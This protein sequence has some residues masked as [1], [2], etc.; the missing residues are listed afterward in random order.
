MADTQLKQPYLLT[1]GYLESASP[2]ALSQPFHVTAQ[3][4]LNA[5]WASKVNANICVGFS[6]KISA[7][8]TPEL[9]IVGTIFTKVKT[10]FNFKAYDADYFKKYNVVLNFDEPI[11]GSTTLNFDAGKI[12]YIASS[13]ESHFY[14]NIVANFNES[15]H[16]L[17]KL[18][19]SIKTEFFTKIQ[20]E[21]I[22]NLCTIEAYVNLGALSKA[23]AKFDLNFIKGVCF[24]IDARYEK[25]VYAILSQSMRCGT[26]IPT[27]HLFDFKQ[28]QG[29]IISNFANTR[30][31]NTKPIIRAIKT[32]FERST[33]LQQDCYV[34]WQENERA[35]I[36]KNIVFDE[37]K[38]LSHIRSTLWQEMI[39]KRKQITYSYE[40]AHVFEKSF[41]FDWDKGL[42]LRLK[43]DLKW[44]EARAIYYQKHDVEPWT[45][46]PEPQY[47]GS[48][49]LNFICLCHDV[50]SH[51]V[52]LNFG[53]SDCLP[54]IANQ[55]WWYIVNEIQVTRLDN[56]EII[57]VLNGNYRTDRQSW[58]WSYSLTIPASELSKLDPVDARPVI[59]KIMVNGFEHLMLL[60]NRTR[61]RQ[62]AQ[63]TY[64]LSGR[65]VSA[66]LDAPSSPPRAFLQENER[67]SVQ[68]VQ[69]EIDRS[70]YPDLD[71]NWQLI[72][73]LGWIV[74]NESFSYSNL[75]PIKAI[76]EIASAGGG[77]VYS[78]ADS[79]TISIK[80][81]YKKTFWNALDIPDYDVLLPESIVLEQS[82]DYENYPDYNGITLT[83]DKSGLTGQ[84]KRTGTSGDVLF[85]TVN[86]PLFTE[87][88]VMASFGKSKLSKAGLVESHTF[89][90]PLTS[91]IGQCKPSD[92][93]AFNAEFWG[94]VDSISV[95]FNYAKVT[96]QIK[97]ER[98]NHG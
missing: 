10:S 13:V 37:G 83:N 18:D 71:L 72:D 34:V 2:S 39:R 49:N 76:Q 73:A 46:Q 48:S 90:M 23:Q 74:P 94:V 56:G 47:I 6:A 61:S 80:P 36:R 86:N 51:N 89:S 54:A 30:F 21:F 32:V 25:A 68:L 31:E 95:S 42:E 40:V 55:N 78:D 64:S 67:T 5:S 8:F 50:D 84:V 81:L 27:L 15:T 44:N 85:E 79:Q 24:G 28:E 9:N 29:L 59:L 87:Q 91:K 63:D 16:V 11:T 60:E 82:T 38:K 35:F 7:E 52:I 92:V 66:L 4:D 97:V 26:A 75:T 65:S 88:N 12:N 53:Q 33:Q 3:Y 70:A 1:S 62:F 20:A 17:A 14:A 98:V 57:N 43:S 22:G 58:C 41:K 45:P 96:Q 77:F 19:T 93:L 69:A